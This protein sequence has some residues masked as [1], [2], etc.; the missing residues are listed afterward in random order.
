MT[1]PRSVAAAAIALALPWVV[2]S[3]ALAF[4]APT[5]AAHSVC[6]DKSLPP[7]GHLSWKI[8]P[9]ETLFSPP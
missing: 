4:E 6:V 9:T 3:T 8:W 7:P 5:S 1:R 2:A